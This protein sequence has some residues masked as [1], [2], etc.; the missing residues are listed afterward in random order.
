MRDPLVTLSNLMRNSVDIDPGVPANDL[1]DVSQNHILHMDNLDAIA[2][3]PHS[4]VDFLYIDPPFA[5]SATYHHQISIPGHTISRP[6]YT[7]QWEHGLSSYLEFLVPRLVAMKSLLKST[8][9][10]CVHLDNHSSHY[11]KLALDAIFGPE[12]LINEVI[13]RYGKMSNTSRRF[14]QNHD[15]LL[16]YAASEDWYFQPIRNQPSEY[17]TRFARDLTGN[18]VLYGTVKHRSDKLIQRRITARQRELGRELTDAD[19]LFDFDS[20]RKVQDDVFTDISIV[21]GNAREGVGYD[22][23]KPQKLLERLTTALCPPGGTV[24]DLFCGSGTTGAAAES[25]NRRW[26]LADR[27]VPAI[28]TTRLRLQDSRHDFFRDSALQPGTFDVGTQGQIIDFRIGE[29]EL[30]AGDCNAVA[31]CLA[32]NPQALI[33]GQIGDVIIDVFGREATAFR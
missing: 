1:L 12:R 30:S 7:D 21:R 32:A 11:V 33:A 26:I 5:S 2:R 28:Q 4:S 10:I 29:L 8:G 9:S 13:W 6:A 19:V 18:K 23:Q 3:I 20:E 27:G 31:T 16:I 25:M 14:P 24:A 15:T 17:R 22:T